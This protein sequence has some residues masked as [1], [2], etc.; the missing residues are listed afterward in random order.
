MKVRQLFLAFGLLTG[1]CAGRTTVAQTVPAI[2]NIQPAAAAV[3]ATVTITGNNFAA[4]AA[5]NIVYFGAVSGQVL[6]A[7]ATA[8]TV[9]VPSGASS[10]VP[11]TVTNLAVQRTG[12]SL[13]SPVPAFKV[14]FPSGPLSANSYRRSDV[15]AGFAVEQAATG[16]F[17]RDGRPDLVVSARNLGGVS[18]LA[19]L[20]NQ[21][22]GSFRAPFSVDANIQPFGVAVGDLN[23]DGNLDIA[24]ANQISQDV[25]V[26]L[27]DG[28]GGFA[29]PT[30]YALSGNG[31]AR[32][33]IADADG[34]GRPDIFTIDRDEVVVMFN[35]GNGLFNTAGPLTATPI[36]L[37]SPWFDV[38][39]FNGD[40][41]LDVVFPA[42]QNGQ[43]GFK[44]LLRPATGFTYVQ[45]FASSNPS[46]L[47]QTVRAADFN[48]DGRADVAA[49][50]ING[51]QIWQR[52]AT[53]TGF[54]APVSNYI[55][56]PFR[57]ALGFTDLN[58]DGN[59]DVY[60][61]ANSDPLKLLVGA[62]T[63]T[64]NTLAV[65]L[66]NPNGSR[67][68]ASA[69]FNGD[70]RPD[71]ATANDFNNSV[72]IFFNQGTLTPGTPTLDAIA[73]Q[74]VA[75]VPTTLTVPLTG[76]GGGGGS[77]VFIRVAAS[78]SDPAQVAAP[79]VSYTSPAT[80]GSLTL[81]VNGPAIITVTVSNGQA[82]NGS[83][84]RSFRVVRTLAAA[85]N[86]GQRPLALYPN[87]S[88]GGRCWLQLPNGR[89][90]TLHLTDPTGRLVLTQELPGGTAPAEVQL[91]A[92]LAQGTYLAS[93]RSGAD[94][95][96]QRLVVLP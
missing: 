34:D 66:N 46:Y 24:A 45:E 59:L 90:A 1:L 92:G 51:L 68:L 77:G 27:G 75:Q 8:L 44:V 4:I 53:G 21:G 54:N 74:V 67:E 84:S 15:N 71:L 11:V 26:I 69:D 22:G 6:T 35:L 88:V 57:I 62:G 5:Q 64:F 32:V 23:G 33:Q 36:I 10:G 61:T 93:L 17:N 37:T 18:G 25:S 19:V 42:V 87:P 52:N 16:D 72:S 2:A 28:Q 50:N 13:A 78:S 56:P 76:I 14:L 82:V 49:T 85:T 55:S 70:G 79:V 47:L 39:D 91:P 73:D 38:A 65:A 89:P 9:A 30:N 40:G 7:S 43:G 94:V 29:T 48:N 95:Y 12:S 63:A 80:V 31:S 96:R 58:G 3:G 41:R 81:A 60:S 83:I 86:Q 20:L